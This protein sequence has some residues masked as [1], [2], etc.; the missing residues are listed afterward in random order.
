MEKVYEVSYN[1][2]FFY[3]YS[4]FYRF[5]ILNIQYEYLFLFFYKINSFSFLE[6]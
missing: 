3:I 2:K 1:V 4:L 6:V 5:F